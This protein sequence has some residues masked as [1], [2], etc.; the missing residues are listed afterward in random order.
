MF[1]RPPSNRR[2]FLRSLIGRAAERVPEGVVAA[3]ATMTGGGTSAPRPSAPPAD[4]AIVRALAVP[5][6]QRDLAQALVRRERLREVAEG[7]Y[8]ELFAFGPPPGGPATAEW[9]ERV[10]QG[11]APERTRPRDVMLVAAARA[12]LARP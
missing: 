3:A 1:D 6:D 12:E 11:R 7:R 2:E 10:R 8:A 4:D 5:P 9:L